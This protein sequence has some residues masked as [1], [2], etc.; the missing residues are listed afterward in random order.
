MLTAPTG[1][2]LVATQA[3]AAGFSGRAARGSV[4]PRS[5]RSYRGINEITVQGHC[6]ALKGQPS[7]CPFR[8]GGR[9][10]TSSDSTA[11]SALCAIFAWAV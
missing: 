5:L 7:R 10:W 9:E 3:T 11:V 2:G 6:L 8:M 1:L 4:D